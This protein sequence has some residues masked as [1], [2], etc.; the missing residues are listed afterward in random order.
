MSQDQQGP[1]AAGEQSPFGRPGAFAS[2]TTTDG[3]SVAAL[4]TGV[5]GLGVVPVVLGIV[6]LKRTKAHGTSGRGLSIAGIV[7]GAVGTVA[8]LVVGVLAFGLATNT[9]D[10]VSTI[11]SAVASETAIAEPNKQP[12]GDAGS[13]TD[14]RTLLRDGVPL[15]VAGLTTAGLA[16]DDATVAA[17]ALEAYTTTY[18]DGTRKVDAVLSHWA[19]VEQAQAWAASQDARFTAAQAV[20][21]GEINDGEV[22]YRYYEVDGVTT[23]VATDAVVALTMT[24]PS[25]AVDVFYQAF[26]I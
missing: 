12:G 6:G 14:S 10:V 16:A 9:A 8:W 13:A 25:D 26:P 7:L 20:K 21:T 24:G 1:D 17:G 11:S 18:T 3:M 5:I 4:V 23:V 15:E 22:K 19:S 2:R